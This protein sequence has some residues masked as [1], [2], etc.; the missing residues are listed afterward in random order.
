MLLFVNTKD[1]LYK[2]QKVL[3][4][5]SYPLMKTNI[6]YC[7]IVT[8]NGWKARDTTNNVLIRDTVK[9]VHTEPPLY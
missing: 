2:V 1:G 8:N 7:C 6:R 3:V 9:T 4:A 5:H